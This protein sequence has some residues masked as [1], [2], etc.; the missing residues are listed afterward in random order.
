[1]V[2]FLAWPLKLLPCAAR[3]TWPRELMV[4]ERDSRGVDLNLTCGLELNPANPVDLQPYR[5]GG[6]MGQTAGLGG[7]LLH[8]SVVAET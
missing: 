8:S 3:Y 5:R 1:M 7:R 2:G 4:L 6:E